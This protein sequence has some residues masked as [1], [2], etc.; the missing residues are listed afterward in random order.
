[1]TESSREPG[2]MWSYKREITYLT[3]SGE[4]TLCAY[5]E[6]VAIIETSLAPPEESD[7]LKKL[8]RPE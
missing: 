3:I 1:M 4:R 5:V 7:F 6:S 8:W 2:E